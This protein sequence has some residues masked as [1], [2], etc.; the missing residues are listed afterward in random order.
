[1]R[2]LVTN[3]DGIEATGIRRLAETARKF[4]E[5][6]VIAPNVQRSA[7]SHCLTFGGSIEIREY[8]YQMEGVKAFS[9]TGTPADCVKI[10][11]S[12]FMNKKP[13]VILSGINEGFN[14]GD[15]IQYSGTANAAFEG[16]LYGILSI[17]ISNGGKGFEIVDA[18]LDKILKDYISKPLPKDQIWNINFPNC[19]LAEC[20]GILRDRSVSRE[21]FWN[22]TYL[23]EKSIDGAYILT[24]HPDRN[25]K[26]GEGTDLA[27]ISENYISIGIAHN[28]Y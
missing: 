17:A 8:D 11:A 9:C 12:M 4:G 18:Y 7:V 14:I 13:D 1:M 24:H 6:W 3:D 21:R 16:S 5:V 28:F 22:D 26:G 20:R 2:I 25:W 23:M 19:S 15:D 10:G 27:A